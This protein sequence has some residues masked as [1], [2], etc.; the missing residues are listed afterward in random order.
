[1]PVS[2]PNRPLSLAAQAVPGKI[3]SVPSAAHFR[4]CSGCDRVTSEAQLGNVLVDFYRCPESMTTLSVLPE[5]QPAP[6]Y[7]RFGPESICYGRSTLGSSA[8]PGGAHLPDLAGHSQFH[9]STLHL[10][11]DAT[12]ILDNLRFERY[13]PIG[14]IGAR[15]LLSSD[16]I[17][18]IYYYIRPWLAKPLRQALQRRYFRNWR[19]LRFP[20]WPVDTTVENILETLLLLSMRSRNL[21]SLPFIWFWPDGAL[22]SA[23]VTHDVETTAGIE[24]IPRLM[25]V[26]E[27]FKI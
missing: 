2:S 4:D 8:D 19:H 9:G 15:A 27:A 6:G 24:F 13:P 10:P 3:E 22:S 21:D 26:D 11:F 16:P 14:T 25:D 23:I 12:E 17:R 5:L 20:K 18:R 1:S 7:F